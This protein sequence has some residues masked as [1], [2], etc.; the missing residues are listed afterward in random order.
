LA[1]GKAFQSQWDIG[2][3]FPHEIGNHAN[4]FHQAK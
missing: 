3:A 4:D 2:Q 1:V